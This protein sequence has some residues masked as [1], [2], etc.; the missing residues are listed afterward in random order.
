M[1]I[2]ALTYFF[3]GTQTEPQRQDLS[4]Q[5]SERSSH[6]KHNIAFFNKQGMHS[7]AYHLRNGPARSWVPYRLPPHQPPLTESRQITAE[8]QWVTVLSSQA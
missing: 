8:E 7:M 4:V 5:G 2:V 3:Q 6:L 1:M